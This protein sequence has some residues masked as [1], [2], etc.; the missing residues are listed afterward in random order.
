MIWLIPCPGF[1]VEIS[2]IPTDR[3]DRKVRQ[4]LLSKQPDSGGMH[5]R[6]RGDCYA[7]AASAFDAGSL[8]PAFNLSRT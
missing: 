2:M 1:V 8:P 5:T 7:L 6:S 3:S 4:T